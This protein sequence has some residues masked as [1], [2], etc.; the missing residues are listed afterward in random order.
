MIIDERRTFLSGILHLNSDSLKVPIKVSQC[1][2]SFCSVCIDDH[3]RGAESWECPNC[4]I[5]NNCKVQSLARNFYL[6]E[7]VQSLTNI[8]TQPNQNSGFDLCCRHQTPIKLRK[9]IL[10]YKSLFLKILT[11]NLT[12]GCMV[13][14]N[15][16]CYECQHDHICGGTTREGCQTIKIDDFE[17]IGI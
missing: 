14:G 11:F 13:H 8:E 4:R 12:S 7:V 2:H 16:L 17:K 6:E 15:S 10:T 5:I 1:G 3:S 9:S